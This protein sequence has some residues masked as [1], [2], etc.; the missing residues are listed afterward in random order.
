MAMH[1]ALYGGQPD[2]NAGEFI[3]SVQAL[4]GLEQPV[5]VGHIEAGTVIRNT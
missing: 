3:L 5:R 1:D 2:A 4:E